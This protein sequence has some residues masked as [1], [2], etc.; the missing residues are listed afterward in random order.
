VDLLRL[1]RGRMG[2]DHVLATAL[3]M[4]NLAADRTKRVLRGRRS[5][6]ACY[7]RFKSALARRAADEGLLGAVSRQMGYRYESPAAGALCA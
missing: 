6:L 4:Q 1:K 5:L 2:R 3:P 7:F